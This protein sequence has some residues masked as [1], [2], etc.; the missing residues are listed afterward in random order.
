MAPLVNEP[1]ADTRDMH[2]AHAALRR[3]FRLLPDVIRSVAPGDTRRAEVVG[4]HAA[5]MCRVLHAHHEGEDRLL[6][7]KLRGARGRGGGGH[8]ADDGAA[9]PR[10]RALYWR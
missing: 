7:P 4:A 3:E 9:A 2:M 6:W 5:L 1:M 10:H 8:R